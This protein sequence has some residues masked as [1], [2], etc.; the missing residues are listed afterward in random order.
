LSTNINDSIEFI[1]MV[2]VWIQPG[3]FKRIPG[4]HYVGLQIDSRDHVE[5]EYLK[6][7]SQVERHLENN[8]PFQ[9][10]WKL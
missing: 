3:N 5:L 2:C 6:K 10:Q 1:R 4:A 9:M 7:M 8:H